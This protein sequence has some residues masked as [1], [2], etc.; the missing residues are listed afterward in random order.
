MITVGSGMRAVSQM[1]AGMAKEKA[2]DARLAVTVVLVATRR[3]RVHPRL[4]HDMAQAIVLRFRW[5]VW[6]PF[7]LRT[8][9]PTR[10]NTTCQRPFRDPLSN[11]PA[12]SPTT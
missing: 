2:D 8:R 4:L 10:K 5:F 7:M 11:F 9:G 12:M 1:E 3:R 6:L